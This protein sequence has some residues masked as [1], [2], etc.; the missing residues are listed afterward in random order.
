MSSLVVALAACGSHAPSGLDGA[1]FGD[2]LA[3]ASSAL[4]VRCDPPRQLGASPW[5]ASA[6]TPEGGGDFA[7]LGRRA[8]LVLV[9][10][11]QRMLVGAHVFFP[12]CDQAA[13][14]ALWRDVAERYDLHARSD[15]PDDPIT[16]YGFH[17]GDLRLDRHGDICELALGHGHGHY[18]VDN[19]FDL[20]FDLG[21]GPDPRVHDPGRR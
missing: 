7:E 3:A 12:A 8:R 20:I 16:H 21:A 17:D 1:H 5:S 13:F 15:T 18:S 14:L 10:D 9:T 4:G 19:P 11:A 6:C 2:D